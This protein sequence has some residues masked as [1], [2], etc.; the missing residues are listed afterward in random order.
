MGFFYL[1]H[2][3]TCYAQPQCRYK[4]LELFMRR[5]FCFPVKCP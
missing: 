5:V 2:T 3:A 4:V 1:L